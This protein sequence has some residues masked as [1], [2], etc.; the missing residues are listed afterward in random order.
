MVAIDET[1]GLIQTFSYW[2]VI[3]ISLAIIEIFIAD[4]ADNI[5]SGSPGHTSDACSRSPPLINPLH[6]VDV[7]LAG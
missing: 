1:H 2:K 6:T 7:T 5:Q 4:N 3:L